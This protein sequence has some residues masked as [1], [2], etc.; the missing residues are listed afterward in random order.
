MPH[1][2]S[3][4][5]PSLVTVLVLAAGGCG[6]RR[7]P[8]LQLAYVPP[9][10]LTA[11][12]VDALVAGPIGR[13]LRSTAGVVRVAAIS[14]D[15][16]VDFYVVGA[17]GSSAGQLAGGARAA[18]A[19]AA[20]D[21]P[22]GGRLANVAFVNSERPI[23]DA[24]PGHV[25]TFS[26]TADAA[27]ASAA[28]ISPADVDSAIAP[29]VARDRPARADQAPALQALTIRGARGAHA[30]LGDIATVSIRPEPTSIRHDF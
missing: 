4:A 28:G 1:L 19:A 11:T 13:R 8:M 12:S 21:L 22:A 18:V 16:E 20:A 25:P 23:P 17:A 5:G 9:A 10:G 27:R 30:R 6:T 7:S 14:S 3:F 29:F 24:D 2:W 15:E 26:V